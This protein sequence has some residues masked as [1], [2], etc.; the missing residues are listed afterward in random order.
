MSDFWV[1]LI[2]IILVFSVFRRYIFFFL[3]RALSRR[4]YDQMNK[5]QGSGSIPPQDETKP[6][7]T[8]TIDASKV[9]KPQKKENDTNGEFVDFEEIK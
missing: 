3:L 9:K 6:E 8:I 7:G 4:L 1:V 2:I 5:Q